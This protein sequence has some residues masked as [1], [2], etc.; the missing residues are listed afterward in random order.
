MFVLTRATHTPPTAL[1]GAPRLGLGT[2]A[3]PLRNAC[4]ARGFFIVCMF[5]VF[6]E[7][8][9]LSEKDRQIARLEGQ[10]EVKYSQFLHQVETLQD[11]L[12]QLSE[13]SRMQVSDSRTF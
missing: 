13:H 12:Q 8:K 10:A 6:A 9:V 2:F 4:T 3:Q 11:Q 5:F 7:Q 1:P